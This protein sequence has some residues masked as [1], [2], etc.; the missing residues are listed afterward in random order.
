[1][2]LINIL[3]PSGTSFFWCFIILSQPLLAT[4]LPKNQALI[5]AS[6]TLS[7]SSISSSLTR[8]KSSRILTKKWREIIENRVYL[9]FFGTFQFQLFLN[10]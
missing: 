7:F 8:L 3:N 9:P 6:L 1:M 4:A 10:I 5:L 2:Q